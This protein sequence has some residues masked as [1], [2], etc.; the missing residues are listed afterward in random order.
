MKNIHNNGFTLVE[1]LAVIIILSL[2]ALIA[3]TAVTKLVADTKSDLSD[4]QMTLIKS[5]AESW[6]AENLT[7]L[8]SAGEC[9]YLTLGELKEAGLMDSKIIDPKTNE[10]LSDDFKVKI[11][12]TLNKH[13]KLI[14]DYEVN[15]ESVEGCS[16]AYSD[17]KVPLNPQGSYLE[18]YI[19]IPSEFSEELYFNGPLKRNQIEKITVTYT[20]EI[21]SNAIGSWDVSADQNGSVMAWYTNVDNNSLYELYIG[22]EGGVK[23]NPSSAGL[24]AYFPNL[25]EIDLGY[26]DTSDVTNMYSM[27]SRSGNLVNLN[28]SNFKTNNVIR[29]DSMFYTNSLE[30][31]DMRNFEFTNVTEYTD[32]FV[33]AKSLKTIYVKDEIAKTFI[34]A[35]LADKN[36]T[37]V[38][39][40]IA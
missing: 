23:A 12:G 11:T 24:F 10:E 32:M 13:D 40:I 4:T 9:K 18:A 1:L 20:K 36:K 21:P 37:G 33:E 2:L 14:I 17:G 16:E 30:V 29:M 8:P 31:I 15:P 6:G 27:F 3:S 35:R 38:N 25:I 22:G 26:L 34:E 19:G 39:V 5:A 7:L 28:L